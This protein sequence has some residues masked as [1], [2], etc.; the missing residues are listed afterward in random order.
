MQLPKKVSDCRVTESP[1]KEI[2]AHIAGRVNGVEVDDRRAQPPVIS[3]KPKLIPS[4][5]ALFWKKR[6]KKS[7]IRFSIP[8]FLS[9]TAII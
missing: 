7:L 5:N 2:M 4:H 9:I 1:P 3:T 8:T 6:F